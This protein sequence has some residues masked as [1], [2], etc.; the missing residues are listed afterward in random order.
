M[1]KRL[2]QFIYIVPLLFLVLFFFYP[3]YSIFALSLAPEGILDLR[4]LRVL[5]SESYY[6]R[7]LWFTVWQATVSTLLT[8]LLGLPAAFVFARYEFRGKTLLQALT[9][10]PFVLP[11]MVVA[12]AF[13]S[14]LGAR[15]RLNGWLMT[16]F[17]LSASP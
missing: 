14:L 3:L 6:A 11:T 13:T 9:T 4:P 17:N 2:S 5:I 10:I 1:H 12:T 8:L 16:I 15:G 7:V